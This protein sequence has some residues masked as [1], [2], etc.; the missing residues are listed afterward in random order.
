[1]KTTILLSDN[2]PCEV[3]TLYLYAL[4]DIGPKDPGEFSYKVKTLLGEIFTQPYDLKTRL[5]KPPTEPPPDSDDTWAM[6][7]WERFQAAI[8]HNQHRFETAEQRAENEAVFILYTCLNPEDRARVVTVEDYDAVYHAAMCPE[9]SR[10]D[11]S[12]VLRNFYQADFD[13]SDI[14]DAL[15]NVKGGSGSYI[16]TRKWEAQLQREL[17][18]SLEEYSQIPV[19]ERA[20]MIA[21]MRI[22]DWLG[23][24]EMDKARRERK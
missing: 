10:E 5:E 20:R 22:D 16:P 14:L 12:T 7:E 13:G 21:E 9:V 2:Q 24:L 11:I 18:L 23:T 4:R 6:T 3:L 8:A 15:Q 17:R 19:G 1:M